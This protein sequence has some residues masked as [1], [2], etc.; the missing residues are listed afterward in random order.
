MV[1]T[2]QID[3]HIS[4]KIWEPFLLL[5]TDK[6]YCFEAFDIFCPNDFRFIL[7]Q[8]DNPHI[9]L[10]IICQSGSAAY[11]IVHKGHQI[12]PC[13]ELCEPCLADIYPAGN[14]FEADGN[15]DYLQ[16]LDESAGGFIK[17]LGM[18]HFR[19]I[20]KDW[21]IDIADR[22]APIIEFIDQGIVYE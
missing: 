19:F 22:F 16:W 3:M 10:A 7:V 12:S 20:D 17:A 18:R 8:K 6:E 5:R 1:R 14:L 9:K 2:E 4:W 15:S 21:V 13:A 11:R